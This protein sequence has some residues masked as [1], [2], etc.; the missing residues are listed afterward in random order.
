MTGN[1]LIFLCNNL[2]LHLFYFLLSTYSTLSINYLFIAAPL[3][4]PTIL[5]GPTIPPTL[6]TL[7]GPTIP[8]TLTTLA[9]P[10]IPP[11]FTTLAGPTAD[12]GY[13][14]TNNFNRFCLF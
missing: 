2:F 7:A 9:G 4:T 3:L 1:K 11:T 14:L 12:N 5:A 6:T 13:S 10:T 8:P